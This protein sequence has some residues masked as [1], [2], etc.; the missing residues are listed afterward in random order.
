MKR[1]NTITVWSFQEN[2]QKIHLDHCN[3]HVDGTVGR[4]TV[5]PS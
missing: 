1:N 4:F 3:A 2:T 5:F